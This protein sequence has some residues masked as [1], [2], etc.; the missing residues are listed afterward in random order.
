MTE[1]T[2]PHWLSPRE[3]W[4]HFAYDIHINCAI[5]KLLHFDSNSSDYIRIGMI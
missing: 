3:N 5:W 2:L 1:H 4:R